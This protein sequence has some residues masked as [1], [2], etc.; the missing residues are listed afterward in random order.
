VGV[1][2]KTH[3][4]WDIDMGHRIWNGDLTNF[5]DSTIQRWDSNLKRIGQNG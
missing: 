3:G 4:T 5:W 2:K 1:H